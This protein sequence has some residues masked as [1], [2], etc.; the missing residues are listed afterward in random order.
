MDARIKSGHDSARKIN[1]VLAVITGLDPVIHS[2]C[3]AP[4]CAMQVKPAQNAPA[5][6]LFGRLESLR[7]LHSVSRAEGA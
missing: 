1:S 4:G 2:R 3:R 5:P 6:L 7:H